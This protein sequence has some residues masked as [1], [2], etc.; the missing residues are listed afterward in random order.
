[1]SA[2]LASL[3][4]SHA[5]VGWVFDARDPDSS[6]EERYFSGWRLPL[7]PHR[8]WKR[9]SPFAIDTEDDGTTILAVSYTHLTLPTN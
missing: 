1:M 5:P 3:D 9:A 7:T 2:I 8:Y 6:V 4:L